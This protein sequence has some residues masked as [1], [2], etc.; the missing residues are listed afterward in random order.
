MAG[1]ISINTNLNSELIDIKVLHGSELSKFIGFCISIERSYNSSTNTSK[2]R[3]F[4]K[5]N[6]FINSSS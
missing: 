4:E 3:I 6:S 2:E 1:S 5:T